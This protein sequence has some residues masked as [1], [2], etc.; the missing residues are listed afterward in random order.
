M[1][2]FI[3]S[4]LMQFFLGQRANSDLSKQDQMLKMALELVKKEIAELILKIIAGTTA[5]GILIYSLIT[6]GQYFHN[7]M[8][9]YQ[10][11]VAFSIIFFVALAAS[12]IFLV[13]QLFYVKKNNLEDPIKSLLSKTTEH[14][15]SLENIYANF[16]E[17][18]STA[19]NQNKT[20]KKAA[21]DKKNLDVEV[22]GLSHH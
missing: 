20:E 2:N 7:F 19:L 13:S 15:I 17:G 5:T 16:F 21:A 6:L 22:T 10:D 18:L 8:L 12:C 4:I 1:G 9:R 11:G 3:F 14:G